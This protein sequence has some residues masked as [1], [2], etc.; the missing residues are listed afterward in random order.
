MLHI[1]FFPRFEV[2]CLLTQSGM[3]YSNLYSIKHVAN[4]MIACNSLTCQEIEI[5]TLSYDTS[6][7]KFAMV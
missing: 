4:R 2:T 7:G 3:A 5:R 1:T 6:E